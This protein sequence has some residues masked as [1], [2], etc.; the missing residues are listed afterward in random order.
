MSHKISWRVSQKQLNRACVYI[1]YLLAFFIPFQLDF[2][3]PQLFGISITPIIVLCFALLFFLIIKV[4]L[5]QRLPI[6]SHW[7]WWLLFVLMASLA[8]AM[9]PQVKGLAQ[10]MWIIFRFAFVPLLFY[11]GATIFLTPA[12][13]QK[14][15]KIIAVSAALTGLIAALQTLSTGS[16]LSGYLTN[17]RYLGLFHPLPSNAV[18]ERLNNLSG[19]VYLSGTNIYRGHGAFYSHNG[20]GAFISVTAGLSWGLL[21]SA[22]K[23]KWFWLAVFIA[24]VIGV[25]TSFSR[26]SWA[27]AVAGI[28]IAVV[29]E[30]MVIGKKRFALRVVKLAPVL[31]ALVIIVGVMVGFSEKIA[32]HFLTI[33]TPEKVP[34]FQWRQ[35]VW[36][37]ALQKIGKHPWI[38]AG[39]PDV[40]TITDLSG[41]TTNYGAHNL[42]IGIAYEMGILNLGLFLLFTTSLF[43][44][45]WHCVKHSPLISDRMLGVGFVAAG[46]AFFVAGVGSALLTIENMAALFWVLAGLAKVMDKSHVA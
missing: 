46:V 3:I 9:G 18:A 15:V 32:E 33:F 23:Y 10:G 1:F 29:L 4:L 41:S 5:F 40:F 17:Q 37:T 22:R 11:A 43:N 27:A 21:R 44:S 2:N 8:Y 12:D 31:L 38:G 19:T 36:E 35:M 6:I 25:I 26:S 30:L 45:A 20:F 24:Q 13:V 39:A 34:Q 42:L 28:G 16:L 7:Q 14:V